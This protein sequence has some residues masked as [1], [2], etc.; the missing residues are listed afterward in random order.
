MRAESP[1]NAPSSMLPNRMPRSRSSGDAPVL[2][3]YTAQRVARPCLDYDAITDLY[4]GASRR[5][6]AIL[7]IDSTAIEK[8]Q[9]GV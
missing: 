7:T 3:P 4:L 1:L 8:T 5:F 9:R 6:I 2:M